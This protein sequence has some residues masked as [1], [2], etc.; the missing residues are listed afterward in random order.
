MKHH[1]KDQNLTNIIRKM[2]REHQKMLSDGVRNELLYQAI[3]ENV[4]EKTRL[5]DIGAGTGVWAIL[6]ALLGAKRVVAVEMHK[7]LIPIIYQHAKENGVA[8]RIEIIHANSDDLKLPDKFDVIVSELFGHDTYGEKTVNSFINLRK[9]F[10][11]KDGVLIP[12]KM[13]Q[14]AVP[15]KIENTV[16]KVGDKLP[17]KSNFFKSLKLNYCNKY[18][19]SERDEIEF[20]SE[21][22]QL[23]EVDFREIK[24]PLQLKNLSQ[25]W[26]LENISKVNAFALYN[27]S[28]YTDAIK[29]DSFDSK[30]WLVGIYEFEP[31]ALKAGEI[32]F[33]ITLK[34]EQFHWKI[35]VPSDPKI[36]VQNYS[37]GFAVSRIIM[38][39]NL[40]P[41][42]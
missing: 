42:A 18:S 39:Q 15:V 8:D 4:S 20:L 9:R 29:L 24:K 17:F 7:Y 26:K 3:K 19:L 31:F 36:K 11:A 2:L 1:I 27:Y 34:K 40:T 13:K 6:A 33:E 30:S 12:Q 32:K 41:K 28:V 21:P 10:L 5:L 22:K 35:S 14:Y 25:S 38:A 16:Q 23:L 37:P